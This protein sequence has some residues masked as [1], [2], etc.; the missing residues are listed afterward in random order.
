[1]QAN[2]RRD[3]QPEVAVRRELHRRGLRFRVDYPPLPSLLRRRADVVFTR[4]RVALFIDGCFWHGC[5]LHGTAQNSKTNADF[6]RVKIQTNQ[7]RDADT[8]DRLRDAGWAVVRAWEHETPMDVADLM[9][10]LLAARG[11]STWP[12][13]H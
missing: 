12:P 10:G 6:W 3:T 9:Q 7:S 4:A 11:A 5:P 1:M 13:C 2:P 8:N